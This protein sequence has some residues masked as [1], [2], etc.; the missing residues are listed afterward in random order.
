MKLYIKL[1]ESFLELIFNIIFKLIRIHHGKIFFFI[2]IA[3]I[4]DVVTNL[5]CKL[6]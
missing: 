2:F 6:L 3:V 1:I 5:V 4:N